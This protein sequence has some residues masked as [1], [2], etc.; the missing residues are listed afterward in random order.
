MSKLTNMKKTILLT[1][2]PFGLTRK[3]SKW[4][5][6]FIGLALVFRG[7]GELVSSNS[8]GWSIIFGL[9]PLIGGLWG[10]A[11][12]FIL[13]DTTNR[14]TPKVVVDENIL[15]IREGFFGRTKLMNWSDVQL[16]EFKS[17]A[18]D[19]LFRDNK[20]QLYILPTTPKIFME[21]KKSIRE[22]ADMK[23]INVKGG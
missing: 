13:F 9:L 17:Y 4:V 8:T 23:L 14:F 22:L 20:T 10:M 21:V 5:F 2:N 12:G 15:T 18:L 6:I 16:I 3:A 11:L 19:F 7:I 1:Q